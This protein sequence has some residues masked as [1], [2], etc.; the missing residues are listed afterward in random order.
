MTLLF[1]NVNTNQTST[2]S[3]K[4][5]NGKK[6]VIVRADNFDG[7]TVIVEIASINDSASRYHPL[8]DGTFTSNGQLI[9]DYLK[10]GTVV[11]ARII[12]AGGS[13]SNIYVEVF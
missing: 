6:L 4:G 13:T 3:I 5:D 7:A 9:I 12:N 11:R 2:E 10:V 1:D 8:A